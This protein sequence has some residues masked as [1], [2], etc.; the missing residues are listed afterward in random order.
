[1]YCY[2]VCVFLCDENTFLIKIKLISQK[3]RFVIA[4]SRKTKREQKNQINII[5]VRTNIADKKQSFKQYNVPLTLVCY[6]LC[7]VTVKQS[8]VYVKSLW[9]FSSAFVMLH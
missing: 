3:M 8:D 7:H 4:Y 9:P 2:E 1:M 6:C 5:L